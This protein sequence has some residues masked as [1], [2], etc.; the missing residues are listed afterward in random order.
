MLQV[1]FGS[2]IGILALLT[3]IGSVAIV[4][5]WIYFWIKHQNKSH[6]DH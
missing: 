4:A 2:S 3:V 5:F 1:L 6:L